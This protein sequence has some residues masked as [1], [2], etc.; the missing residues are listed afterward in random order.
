MYLSCSTLCFELADHPDIRKVLETIKALGFGA[1]DLAAFEGWQNVNP[2]SLA[3]G[4]ERWIRHFLKALDATELAVS[5]FNCGFSFQV[6]DP[7]SSATDRIAQEF[8]ALLDLAS[9]VRCPNLTVQPGRSITGYDDEELFD[10]ARTRLAELGRRAQARGLTLSVEGHQ[11]SLLE[12][13]VT[14]MRMMDALWP[15]V[16]FTYDP[17]HWA[18]QRIPLP[19]TEPLLAVTYH[20]HVRDAAPDAMQAVMGQGDVDFD[21]L[22]STLQARAYEGAIAIEYFNGFDADLTSTRALRERMV[23]LGV[24]L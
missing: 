7:D 22:V 23:D 19:E 21:W 11:G 2:S 15:V 14:A 18:M 4:D 13:P 17:S 12:D 3:A 1:V 16:G 8:E 6:D 9:R 5:S 24:S 10:V 20:V